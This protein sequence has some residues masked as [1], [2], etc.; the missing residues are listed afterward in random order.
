MSPMLLN[1]AMVDI[2]REV[3]ELK[4]INSLRT[5]CYGLGRENLKMKGSK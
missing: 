4:T 2:M 3:E 5:L 1:T